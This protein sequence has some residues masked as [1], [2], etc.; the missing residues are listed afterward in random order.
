MR[1]KNAEVL[2]VGV[3]ELA[4]LPSGWKHNIHHRH[5]ESTEKK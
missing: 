2:N 1:I 4:S 5:T 3:P